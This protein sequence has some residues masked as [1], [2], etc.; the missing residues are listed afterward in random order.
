MLLG[1]SVTPVA[2]RRPTKLAREILTL[3]QLAGER[4]IFGAGAGVAPSEFD[5]LGD[6]GD[7]KI[8]AEMLDEGLQLLQELWS[9]GWR[10]GAGCR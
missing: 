9:A 4:F 1:T 5:S 7:L 10:G 8:R 3:H 2:R 6:E